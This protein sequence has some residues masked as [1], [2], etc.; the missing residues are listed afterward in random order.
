MN[1]IS[2]TNT[3]QQSLKTTENDKVLPS[4]V[5]A[6]RNTHIWAFVGSVFE[7]ALLRGLLDWSWSLQ[8]PTEF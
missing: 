8:I 1:N 3:G 7:V 5:V 2:G 4:S 6:I